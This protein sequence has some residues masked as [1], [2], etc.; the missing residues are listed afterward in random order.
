MART[1]AKLSPAKVKNAKKPGLYGDG[2]GLYLHVGPTGGKSWVYRFMLDGRA[3]E[4][5]LGPEHT[6]GL[7]RA[8]ELALECRQQRHAGVDPLEF[9]PGTT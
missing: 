6:I 9:A 2:A 7:A 1:I 5:G 8:R 4:M 3:R